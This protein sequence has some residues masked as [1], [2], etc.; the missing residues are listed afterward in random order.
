MG[1][2]G[3]RMLKEPGERPGSCLS[4]RGFFLL[5]GAPLL[6][7]ALHTAR[8]VDQLLTARIVRVTHRADIQV[9]VLLRAARLVLVTAGAMDHCCHVLRM[10]AV[11]HNSSAVWRVVQPSI[12]AEK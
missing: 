8:R 12:L 11:F 3:T 7:E 4:L 6:P 10:N 2:L 5:P 9:N 1:R